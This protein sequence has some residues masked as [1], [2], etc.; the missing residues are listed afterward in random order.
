MRIPFSLVISFASVQDILWECSLLGILNVSQAGT[1]A[2]FRALRAKACEGESGPEKRQC[3]PQ[4][5]LARGDLAEG[6]RCLGDGGG[7]VGALETKGRRRPEPLCTEG[8][9]PPPAAPPCSALLRSS[10][11]LRPRCSTSHPVV[12]YGNSV[13]RSH[14]TFSGM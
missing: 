6:S 7:G 1:K 10:G 8:G 12:C 9:R 4:D 5:G 14:V 2:P 3:A 13:K 11:T